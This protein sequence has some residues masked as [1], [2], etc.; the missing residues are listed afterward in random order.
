M[1]GLT[2]LLFL[3]K[4]KYVMNFVKINKGV[5]IDITRVLCFYT[6]DSKVVI[7][8]SGVREPLEECYANEEQALKVYNLLNE[9][10]RCSN[11]SNK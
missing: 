9:K 2:P 6:E 1:E 10:L 11:L 5:S 7:R 8:L 4:K 3:T